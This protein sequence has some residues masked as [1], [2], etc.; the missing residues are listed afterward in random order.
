MPNRKTSSKLIAILGALATLST[1]RSD[2]TAEVQSERKTIDKEIGEDEVLSDPKVR[3]ALADVTNRVV[4]AAPP[5]D[6]QVSAAD[7]AADADGNS[8]EGEQQ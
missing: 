2:Q 7:A 1:L 4:A 3:A 8:G 5:T 6:E